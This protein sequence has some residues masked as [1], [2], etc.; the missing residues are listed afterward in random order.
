VPVEVRLY[1]RLFKVERPDLEEG[2]FEEYLNPNSLEVLTD[3]RLEPAAADPEM[4]ERLQ[5]ERQ[6]YF[7]R[8]PVDTRPDHLVF[9][10]TVPLRDSWAQEVQKQSPAAAAPPRPAEPKKAKAP[11]DTEE[12][13][14]PPL[15]AEELEQLERLRAELLSTVQEVFAAHPK[16]VERYRAGQTGVQGFLMAQVMKRAGA[17]KPSPKLVNALVTR[18]LEG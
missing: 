13:A 9:N 12:K 11:K 10:R 7:Y 5:F 8:D 1:D 16:E 14:P 3:S 17:G 18:E 4:G 15:T 2:S 6:G